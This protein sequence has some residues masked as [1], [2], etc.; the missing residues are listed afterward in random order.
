MTSSL[1]DD[2]NDEIVVGVTSKAMINV[3][4]QDSYLPI[5][6]VAGDLILEID[7]TDGRTYVMRVETLLRENVL[8]SKF[9]AGENRLEREVVP[10][11]FR[12][13]VRLGRID[14]APDVVVISVGV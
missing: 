12:G 8:E 7:F 5:K 13:P 1:R 11:I 14:Y 6:A 2:F 4:S 3:G 10:R 9:C